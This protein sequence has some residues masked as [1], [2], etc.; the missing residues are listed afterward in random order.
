MAGHGYP[1]RK[2]SSLVLAEAHCW[3]DAPHRLPF[4]LHSSRVR[5]S[6][7]APPRSHLPLAQGMGWLL[8]V[9][10]AP[11]VRLLQPHLWIPRA[12]PGS[13]VQ[14]D[15]AELFGAYFK[16]VSK[17]LHLNI[18]DLQRGA[19]P[20]GCSSWSQPYGAELVA[21]EWWRERRGQGKAVNQ[22]P[23]GDLESPGGLSPHTS[24]TLRCW[25]VLVSLGMREQCP[26]PG[27]ALLCPGP[28][29]ESAPPAQQG[30]NK[31]LMAKPQD[32]GGEGRPLQSVRARLQSPGCV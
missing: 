2:S 15:T 4:P 10:Q 30:N 21:A 26:K 24:G 6:Q 32:P 22:D 13:R 8:L 11:S 31:S 3:L 14:L 17:L 23:L 18:P 19:G 16:M 25:A 20:G 27:L 12:N 28:S 5:L 7:L 29:G 1:C 9:A